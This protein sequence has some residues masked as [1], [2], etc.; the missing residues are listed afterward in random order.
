MPRLERR[1]EVLA[2]NLPGHAGGSP[3]PDK[4]DAETLVS[5]V[6]R[7][8]DEVGWET[9]FVA[10]NSLGGWVALQL[11]ARGR[12]R[13]VVALAPAGGWA[14]GDPIAAD[15]LDHFTNMRALV[16]G[17]A[18]YADEIVATPEG[19]RRV[20]Q[21]ITVSFEHI[22]PELLAHQ[23][24]GVADCHGADSLIAW[25]RQYGYPLATERITCPLRIIWGTEDRLL[26]WPRAASRYRELLSWAEWVELPGV[27]HC[28][29]LDVPA[30]T[31]ELILGFTARGG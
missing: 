21:D 20:T 5:G 8:M 22:P 23:V 31:A 7:A 30:Q 3:L 26:R 16:R 29:Q 27:G 10:G 12:A 4:L 17:A 19:R 13:K 14:Q 2:P 6:E 24:R 1:H 28:P 11:A 25:A 18:P 9:A 15:R